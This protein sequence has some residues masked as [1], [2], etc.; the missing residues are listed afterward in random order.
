[1]TAETL[2]SLELALAESLP[3][4]MLPPES[5]RMIPPRVAVIFPALRLPLPAP[6]LMPRATMSLPPMVTPP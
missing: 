3:T 2:P 4:A 5:L 6:R 1:M